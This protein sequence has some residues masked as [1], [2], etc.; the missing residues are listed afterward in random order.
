MDVYGKNPTATSGE[1]FRA[2]IWTWPAIHEITVRL[3]HD[4]L[5][6]EL[7]EAIQYNDG[8]GPDDGE[9]CREMAR[10]IRKWLKGNPNG[11]SVFVEHECTLA[12]QVE[13]QLAK[14]GFQVRPGSETSSRTADAE[15]LHDWIDFLEHCGGFAVS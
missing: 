5:G 14:A 15:H 12:G 8:F 10:R 11:H 3:C 6:D 1:Y 2:S 9:L 4:L 13:A 7:V